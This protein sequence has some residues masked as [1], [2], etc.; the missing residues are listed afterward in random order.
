MSEL[1]PREKLTRDLD[2]TTWS[3]LRPHAIAERMFLVSRDL[4][5][6]EVAVAVADDESARVD[7][8]ISSG[9]ITRPSL[10]QQSVWE[11]TTELIFRCVIVQPF[12]LAHELPESEWAPPPEERDPK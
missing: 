1:E 7:A 3:D 12:V 4:D 6:I 2:I 9:K 5:L 11:G 10:E 8:W